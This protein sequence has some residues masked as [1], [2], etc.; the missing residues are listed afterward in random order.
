MATLYRKR[1]GCGAIARRTGNSG[2]KRLVS[3][4]ASKIAT[5]NNLPST[6]V[7]QGILSWTI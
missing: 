2:V 6:F 3:D 7:F 5:Y 1:I 4:Y